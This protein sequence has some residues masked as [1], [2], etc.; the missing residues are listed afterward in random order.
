MAVSGRRWS[1]SKLPRRRTQAELRPS[2]A[3]TLSCALATALEVE[4]QLP[5][6][7]ARR[8]TVEILR[9]AKEAAPDALTEGVEVKDLE[10]F[11]V[12]VSLDGRGMDVNLMVMRSGTVGWY[13][14]GRYS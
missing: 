12:Q 9:A 6:D 7:E 5:R 4:E 13:D 1:Q 11:P 2:P 8:V 10:D 14:L 3:Q